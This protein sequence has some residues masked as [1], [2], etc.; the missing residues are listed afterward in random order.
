MPLNRPAK[1]LLVVPVSAERQHLARLLE[2][3][4]MIVADFPSAS[5]V[6]AAGEGIDLALLALAQIDIPAR[7]FIAHLR[8]FPQQENLPILALIPENDQA[9]EQA[10]NAGADD[11]AAQP[12]I[13]AALMRRVA[14]MLDRQAAQRDLA[15]S[16]Y[17]WT[18]TFTRGRV[19][20][21]LVDPVSGLITDAN[22]AAVEFY[23]YP[24]EALQQKHLFDLTVTGDEP[25][26]SEASAALNYR[27]QLA[28]GM[29]RAVNLFNDRVEIDGV[30][31]LH[32]TVFDN[33]NRLRAEQDAEEQRRL[34]Q[35]LRNTAAAVAQSLELEEVLDQI[36]DEVY[37]IVH[38]DAANVMLIEE[39]TAY[40]VRLRGYKAYASDEQILNT[41]FKISET[42]NLQEMIKTRRPLNIPDVRNFE[43]WVDKVTPYWIGSFLGTP[44]FDGQ[45]LFGFL[46]VD[47]ASTNAFT[48]L[49]VERL[50]AFAVSTAVALRNARLYDNLREQAAQLE[51]RVAERTAELV[52][53]RAQLQSILDAMVEG[54]IYAE[55]T[56]DDVNIRYTNLALNDLLGFSTE[57]L[58]EQEELMRPLGMSHEGYTYRLQ[59]LLQTLQREGKFYSEVKFKHKNGS[60]L[61]AVINVSAVKH[62]NGSLAGAVS[63]IRDI[64]REQELQAQR[65]RFVA[66]ASHEL[67]TPITNLKTRLY[68]LRKQPERLEQ[69][70]SVLDDVT[71]RMRG[72]VEGLLDVTRF[73]RGMIHLDKHPVPLQ[74]LIKRSVTVQIPEADR[75]RQSLV[76]DLPDK[77]ILVEVDG[78]RIIQVITNLVT[79]A[80]NYTPPEGKI[81][82][83][84]FTLNSHGQ[85]YSV[86]EVQDTGIGIAQ[87]HLPYLF[88]PFYRVQSKIEGTG[89]GLP[90]SKEIIELHGGKIEVK[91]EQGSG[92]TFSFYLPMSATD[93]PAD[94]NQSSRF[95]PH[96]SSAPV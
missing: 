44:I 64:S 3:G 42:S 6:D 88:Q 78:D 89:L 37:K 85:E 58:A 16:E 46:I 49:D 94:K 90:I 45:T 65:T 69:H 92:T 60:I 15:R 26:S 86:V 36:L 77:P 67:R 48:N 84:S 28:S 74:L 47:S 71:D 62:P 57:E 31:L 55:F 29:L 82:V 13:A 53:G 19:P 81:I 12:V 83:R 14:H 43:G 70:L 95:N 2:A 73:E 11:Y 76:T 32:T 75:K 72:L 39:D 1:I 18:Q 50:Q 34:A 4:G 80:I 63:V 25:I 56:G 38:P 22:I 27:Q 41:R 79:N 30:S 21:L 96:N 91:S 7:E 9:V 8:A 54:V 10:L 35:A 24:L 20:Q 66:Y 52:N 33:S 23:G 17:R 93:Q 5:A 68:L 61:D 40:V 51:A 59:A 87:E